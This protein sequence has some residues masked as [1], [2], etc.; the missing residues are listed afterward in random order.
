MLDIDEFQQ[1]DGLDTIQPSSSVFVDSSTIGFGDDN[2]DGLTAATKSTI[3]ASVSIGEPKN[4]KGD[5]RYKS[6]YA[7][8]I[9]YGFVLKKYKYT[10]D[11]GY[12]N[13]VFRLMKSTDAAEAEH[14]DLQDNDGHTYKIAEA[15]AFERRCL[16]RNMDKMKAYARTQGGSARKDME[17]LRMDTGFDEQEEEKKPSYDV[18]EL[19]GP[20][21]ERKK[22]VVIC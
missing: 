4:N 7:T 11:D 13:T 9:T 20:Q 15:F 5:D 6:I 18:Q 16:R 22:P 1:L 12:I 14:G 2:L 21:G 3:D 8:A 10:T 17:A 19:M